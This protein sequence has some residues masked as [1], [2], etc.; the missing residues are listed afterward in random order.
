MTI[1]VSTQ[2]G[3][4]FSR[5]AYYRIDAGKV[6][7]EEE[8]PV[9]PGGVDALVRQLVGLEVDLIIASRMAQSVEQ[10]LREAGINVISGID[11][12]AASVMSAYLRGELA[13]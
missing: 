13:F 8:A 9:A 2:W 11:G 4:N 6:R 10:R 3:E 7:E 5:F 12:R 1:A